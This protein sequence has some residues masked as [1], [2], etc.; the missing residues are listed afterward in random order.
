M[1]NE[2][3][4]MLSK[5][6]KTIDDKEGS[7]PDLY[8]VPKQE[9]VDE[10]LNSE[11]TNH[12]IDEFISETN[13]KY[14]FELSNEDKSNKTNELLQ[15]IKNKYDSERLALL[16]HDCEK[17]VIDSIIQPFGLAG[18]I[19]EDRNGGNVDTIH[20]AREG[21]YATD[22]NK[23]KYDNRPDYDSDPYHKHANYINKYRQAS[24]DKDNGT[25][26]DAYTGKTAK[27]NANNDLDHTISAKEI[28]DD[29]GRILAGLDGADLACDDS[30]LNSTDRSINRSKKEK[31]V[32]EF[33][34]TLERD[35]EKRQ[36]RIEELKNKTGLSDK[37][38]KELNKLQKLENIDIDALRKKDSEARQEYEKKINKT[39]YT[40]KEFITNVGKTSVKE[41]FKMGTKQAMGILVREFT[42]AIFSEAKDIF[43]HRHNIKINA[44]FLQSLKE[45]FERISKRV[46]SKWK[47]VVISFKDGAISGFFSNIITVII[48][49]FFTTSERLV[50]MIREGFYSL[51]RAIKMLMSP[52]EGMTKEEA[53]HEATKLIASG[54]IVTGGIA[55]EEVLQ[56]SLAGIPGVSLFADI[57]SSVILG[58]V[59]GLSMALI[60]YLIDKIDLFNVNANKLKQYIDT[61]LDTMIAA[62][63]SEI[64]DCNNYLEG[65]LGI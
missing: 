39:Y 31:S 9:L 54:L 44:E 12:V 15:V 28:D 52:P 5:I 45:R 18:M 60:V 50:K 29:P 40:S 4:E 6:K 14:N 38:Q 47:D 19:F 10:F 41:G 2:I 36:N 25:L 21:V 59:T 57:L 27:R 65:S 49:S 1:Q 43:S 24:E 62:D 56:K 16:V 61:E 23:N 55:I 58:I 51:L 20:N 30:N 33:I 26:K 35:K 17:S 13:E 63:L 64:D 3:S 11:S 53:A 34:K 48:N 7:K 22:E 37:E 8:I 32:E 46:I 42:L